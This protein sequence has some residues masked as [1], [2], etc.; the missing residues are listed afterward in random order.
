MRLNLGL[1]LAEQRGAAIQKITELARAAHVA[2][3]DA[4]GYTLEHA[5][6]FN[7]SNPAARA[8]LVFH[9]HVQ[10]ERHLAIFRARG[11]PNGSVLAEILRDF[12]ATLAR[13]TEE[14]SS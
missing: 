10:E 2:H 1:P 14:A 8:S 5:A 7:T 12:E 11:A 13:A 4:G 6:H 3:E 9:A